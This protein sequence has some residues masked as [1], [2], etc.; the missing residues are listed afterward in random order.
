MIVHFFPYEKFTLNYIAF[1]N[2]NF[3]LK[4]HYFILHG[5]Y[6]LVE[7]NVNN[8]ENVIDY[9]ENE[10]E[11][12][13]LLDSAD[14]IIIHS[15]F[16]NK[17][18]IIM[19]NKHSS[20]L[21]KAGWVVWGGDL[22]SFIGKH[23]SIKSKGKYFLLKRIIKKL[24]AIIVLASG[25]YDLLANHMKIIGKRF[26]GVYGNGNMLKLLSKIEKDNEKK[27]K[28]FKEERITRILV[29]NS[30]TETNYHKEVFSLLEKYKEE[31]I[32]IIVPLSYGDK[33]YGNEI[34]NLGF[35]LFGDKFEPLL[36]FMEYE[37]YL[38]L[39]STID[40]AIFNNNRQQALGNIRALAY[41]KTKLYM[42]LDTS[43]GKEFDRDFRI[44]P[45]SEIVDLNFNEFKHFS[46]N[47]GEY[48]KLAAMKVYDETAA[49]KQWK[50]IFDYLS[51]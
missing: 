24:K 18:P 12:I 36:D 44:R 35:S 16:I 48:N 6:D 10:K 3:N 23:N 4:E 34:V 19:F 1:I 42:R 51:K 40:V 41:F 20:W 33:E 17:K 39:L 8:F 27:E 29:G 30:A 7:I 43:M 9:E 32:R 49:K 25:D 46:S 45:V 5:S 22:H 14:A 2:D 15:L 50:E 31:P 13:T 38:R 21:S 26:T 47:D 37:A 11:A 28:I